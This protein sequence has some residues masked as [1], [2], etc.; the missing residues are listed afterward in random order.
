M[1]PAVSC[2]DSVLLGAYL[3]DARIGSVNPRLTAFGAFPLLFF[4]FLAIRWRAT[5]RISPPSKDKP[6]QLRD[7]SETRNWR[8]VVALAIPISVVLFGGATLR[9]SWWEMVFLHRFDLLLIGTILAGILLAGI[10]L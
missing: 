6:A 2:S 8:W 4:L 9:W 7:W 10:L 1:E 3:V 5:K